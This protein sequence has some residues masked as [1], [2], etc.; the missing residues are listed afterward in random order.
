[1]KETKYEINT[2]NGGVFSRCGVSFTPERKT[3][4]VGE[5]APGQEKLPPHQ[6]KP[7]EGADLSVSQMSWIERAQR[8]AENPG[9]VLAIHGAA[10]K[11]EAPKDP[12]KK[13]GK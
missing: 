7:V 8:T 11:A 2:L 4:T 10:P 5:D 9:G 13:G 3:V 1:M 6:R 12:G